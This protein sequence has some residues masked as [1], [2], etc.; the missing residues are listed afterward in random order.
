[1]TSRSPLT[2]W[3]GPDIGDEV[4]WRLELPPARHERLSDFR[5]ALLP[6]P[7]WL[8]VD[9]EIAAGIEALTSKLASLGAR[10]SEAQPDGFG[11]LREH[12]HL[13]SM[14]VTSI[15]S[16]GLPADLRRERAA[17]GRAR[18]QPFDEAGAR[19][20][21]STAGDYIIWH[22]QRESF[23]ARWRAFFQ[24]W[25]VLLAP[26]VMVPAPPHSTLRMD[27]RVI[28]IDGKT[29]QHSVQ[30]AYAGLSVLTGQPAT[31]FPLGL[32]RHGLPIGIQAI[33]PYLEDRT[34][35]RFAG[36][37]ADEIGGYQ[38]PPGYE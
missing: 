4:G 16:L 2:L 20:L 32:T 26:I 18:G 30:L 34:P 11:D 36:L 33:G 21:E 6:R 29:V 22:G 28:T 8:P 3:P 27:Q 10:V 14:I 24:E 13:Y 15:M 17:L 23:R 1:M 31:A 9:P 7:D 25:D 37:V 35:I 38:R 19:G 12:H 5:V